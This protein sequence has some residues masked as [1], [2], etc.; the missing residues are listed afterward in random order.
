M[1]EE[2][3]AVVVVEPPLGV[4]GLQVYEVEFLEVVVVAVGAPLVPPGAAVEELPVAVL[5]VLLEVEQVAAP[6]VLDEWGQEEGAT[7]AVEGGRIMPY[8]F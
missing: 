4:L 8:F 7:A 1:A 6:A 2:E 5:V 3:A